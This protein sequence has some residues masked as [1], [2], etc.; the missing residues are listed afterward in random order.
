MKEYWHNVFG[1]IS[2]NPH[3]KFIWE[4]YASS[5]EKA[6]ESAK[7]ANEYFAKYSRVYAREVYGWE[8]RPP[9]NMPHDAGERKGKAHPE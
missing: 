4:G 9:R 1:Y 3:T 7:H 8:K 2:T 6:I 5:K